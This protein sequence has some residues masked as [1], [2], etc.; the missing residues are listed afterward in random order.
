[1]GNTETIFPPKGYRFLR[2]GEDVRI[3]DLCFNVLDNDWH[4]VNE[5]IVVTAEAFGHKMTK[6]M[7]RVMPVRKVEVEDGR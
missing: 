2:E 4:P 5:A 3:G 7:F 1:M 6:D